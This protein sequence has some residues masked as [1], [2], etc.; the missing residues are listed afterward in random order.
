MNSSA[1]AGS[2]VALIPYLA[3]LTAA[4]G[5]VT[6]AFAVLAYRR[7]GRIEIARLQKQIFDDLYLGGKLDGIRQRLDFDYAADM[8]TLIKRVTD[9]PDA[10]VTKEERS[11]LLELDRFLNLIE[12]VLYLE[13]DKGLLTEQDRELLLGYW[14]KRI[15]GPT[16]SELRRYIDAY[17]YE[18]LTKCLKA[19]AAQIKG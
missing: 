6:A 7:A 1:E 9:K 14:M 12:Y 10:P 3:F 2:V 8:E 5:V 13:Q 16:C 18:R 11:L 15:G 17:D 4:V 19:M